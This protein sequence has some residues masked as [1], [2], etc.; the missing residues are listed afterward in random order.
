MRLAICGS[1]TGP[2]LFDLMELFGFEE[3]KDRLNKYIDEFNYENKSNILDKNFVERIIDGDLASDKWGG[4]VHTRFPPEPNGYL[5]IGHA[6]SICLNFDLAKQYGG[7]C[8][9]RFDDTNPLKE[10]SEFVESISEDVKWLG[11]NWNG[12][13]LF[14]SD[15]FNEMY[16]YALKLVELGKAYVCDQNP[17]DI[18]KCRGTLTMPGVESPYRNRSVNENL[19]LFQ[20]MKNGTFKNG[21][22][23]RLELKLICLI[24]ILICVIPL[25]TVFC[26]QAS[27]NRKKMVYLS[28]V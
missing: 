13:P 9:L 26:M 6:K 4:R 18:K 17:E 1:L 12:N 5:H 3:Y 24:L 25:S 20:E 10:E 15:Y 16:N 23:R 28:D 27:Q 22:R 8:N 7:K 11:Y 21:E 19:E 2:S 14:A